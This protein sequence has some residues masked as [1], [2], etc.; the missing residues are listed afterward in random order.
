LLPENG[1]PNYS[2]VHLLAQ[3]FPLGFQSLPLLLKFTGKNR[4]FVPASTLRN[5]LKT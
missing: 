4:F 5:I 3:I 2:T 1:R